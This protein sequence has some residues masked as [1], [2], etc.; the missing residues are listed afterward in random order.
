M[1]RKE[2]SVIKVLIFDLDGTLIDSA[3]DIINAVNTLMHLRGRP[4]LP[5]QQIKT[6]IGEG[7]RAMI[8]K[9][10]PETGSDIELRDELEK[11]FNEVYGENLFQYTTIYPGVL[12][13]L[14]RSEKQ[15][16]IVSNKNERFV[17]EVVSGLAL[18]EYKWLRLYGA[19]SLA[20]RKPDPLPLQ[21]VM[22]AAGV[23]PFETLMIGDGLPD[24]QAAKAAGV[25]A[26]AVDHGYT[27][28]QKLMQAGA[29]YVLSDFS[30]LQKL[31]IQ[32]EGH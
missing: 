1:Q 2:F 30:R 23:T 7:L 27:E 12:D 29:R 8:V 21:E 17:K 15:F 28:V 5:E 3:P 32:I 25:T 31:L 19:D 22:K 10:F 9:L 24:M 6:A 18:N 11:D 13:F 20:K 26:I 14:D 4:M 16:A